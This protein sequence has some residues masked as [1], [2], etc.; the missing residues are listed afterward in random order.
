M[1][2]ETISSLVIHSTEKLLSTNFF[3]SRVIYQLHMIVNERLRTCVCV[4]VEICSLFT[5]QT[6]NIFHV[7]NLYDK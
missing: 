7:I 5:V 6:S 2:A 4:C 1:I 3:D